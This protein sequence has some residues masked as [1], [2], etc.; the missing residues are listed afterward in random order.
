MCREIFFL[1]L[2]THL[3]ISLEFIPGFFYTP[4][5]S[6]QRRQP[7]LIF[8]EVPQ[9][10]I[11]YKPFRILSQF[12][13]LQTD[14]LPDQR[15]LTLKDVFSVP[16]DVYPVGRLDYDS[17]GLLILTNDTGLNHRL[18]HPVFSHEREY[19]VQVEGLI[20]EEGLQLLRGGIEI[21]I[22]G[23]G[24]VCRKCVAEKFEAKPAVPPREPPIRMRKNIPDSW[25][26]LILY[27]GKN[28]QVRRMTAK[29]GFPTLRLIRHRIQKL[30]LGELQPGSIRE[31][32]GK[33]IY[34]LLF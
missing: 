3:H 15:K 12:G 25:I 32:T 23:K 26:K 8:I 1:Y 5:C 21:T 28:R 2:L 16:A 24:Y 11:I 9:Y 6:P 33:E 29:A 14:P 19:W 7:L 18:L 34:S 4:P 17:E 20:H 13:S 27:E 31:L 22:D 10:F 30:T